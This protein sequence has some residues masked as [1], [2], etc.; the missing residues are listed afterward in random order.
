MKTTFRGYLLSIPL[1]LF[2]GAL[3]SCASQRDP[4]NRVQPNYLKKAQLDGEW[5]YQ[6]TVVD[7][8]AS[9][10]FTFVGNTDH[11]GISRVTW[12][13]QE[14]FLFARRTTEIIKGADDKAANPEKYKGE[15]IAT[16]RITSHFDIIKA[17]NP[18]TGEEL[19]IINENTTDRPWYERTYIRVDWA[20]NLVTNY[21]LD[22][23]S[24][25]IESVP[26]Y[27]QEFDKDTGERNVDAP[28]FEEDGSY[29][30]VTSRIFA[31]AGT[32]TFPGWGTYPLCWFRGEE[33]T[34]CGTGEYGIRHSFKRID[35]DHQYE[36]LPFKG[37]QTEVFGYFTTDR[38]VYNPQT[39]IREQGKERYLNRHN[40]WKRW[41]DDNGDLI[42]YAKRE[43]RPIVYFVNRGMPEDLK[44]VMRNVAAQYNATFVDI[45]RELGHEPAG[46]V[47]I[48]CPNNPVIEGDPAECGKVGNSPRLGDLRYSFM[49]YVP[50]YMTY[51]LLGLGPSNNDPETGEIISG[52]GY[53]YHHNNTAAYRTQEMIELLNGN[54]NPETYVSG[55]DLTEW[56]QQVN[57]GTQSQGKIHGLDKANHMVDS[58]ANGWRSKFWEGS[59]VEITPADEQ[60][61]RTMGFDK[62]VRPHFDKIYE[63]GFSN[64]EKHS[65]AGRLGQLKGT[66]IEDLMLDKEILLATGLDPNQRPSEDQ[67]DLASLVRGGFTDTAKTRAELRQM[68]A[69][70]HNMYL[71]EMADDALMGLAR[72]LKDTPSE[73]TYDIIRRTIYTAVMAHEVGHS[74]G[75][76]HNFGGSDDAINYHDKYWQIRDDGNVGP[77]TIDPITE[78]EV[79]AKIYNYAYSSV[80]DYAGRYTIDGE[81]IGKYDKAAL[82]FG[83]AQK[84]QVFNDTG[85]MTHEAMGAWYD[86]SGEILQF[87]NVGPQAVHY[88]TFYKQM[89]EK[90]YEASNRKWVDAD[91]FSADFA[92]STV[93]GETR[94]R[95][96]YIY[97]S[98]SRA[99]LGDSCLTRDFG[100][101]SMERMSNML[102]ELNTWYIQRSFPRG[103]IGF[104]N[105]SYI[106]AYYRRVY[107][108]LKGWNDLYGLY[109]DLLPTFYTAD[110][111][112]N[113]LVDPVNGWGDKTWAVQNAFNYLIQTI[114]TPD[115]GNYGGPVPQADGTSALEKNYGSTKI[116][117]TN[118]RYY[119]TS[120]SDGDR[121]CGYEWWE[122]LHHVGNY[123][124]KIMAVIALT[125]TRTN[126]VGRS[127]PEDIREWEVGYYNTFPEQIARINSA[128]MSQDFSQIGPYLENGVVK[129][130]N[131][132]GDMAQSNSG[133]VNP[134]ATFSIQLYWQVLGQ[135]RFFS[136]FDQS[137]L[138]D[139]TVFV[140]G[141]GAAPTIDESK[142]YTFKD[143]VTNITYAAYKFDDHVGGG[144]DVLRRANAMRSRS[145]LCDSTNASSSTDDDCISSSFS[146]DR[147]DSEMKSHVEMIKVMADL[148]PMMRYGNPFNP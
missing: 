146:K 87:L 92:T 133:L 58:I 50:K 110:Q 94:A 131:Y 127:T 100:A 104:S 119:Q 147:A 97:C 16:F 118:G 108:R 74:L 47:F 25:S 17:Y 5:Y 93:D 91:T 115:V 24:T 72:E 7:V 22:F 114:L 63:I 129:Y 111:V 49:A 68:Y 142:L 1:M 46:D 62:W 38:L 89:K 141:S 9:N 85:G 35:P 78:Q 36:P 76:M 41:R 140:L 67:K 57:S 56:I 29:F 6:R 98:H 128:M 84:I 51:G 8:P 55:V 80:M 21:N 121:E 39:G 26:Y 123:L 122:C 86:Q 14:N 53:V 10:G 112:K 19:N 143:P 3:V 27:V 77:R 101:D 126:F 105:W 33:F 30:D 2:I 34:E 32:V 90:L 130:P 73:E 81:G 132:T 107:D 135:A 20:Q 125:D 54:R 52:I 106:N 23:E 103:A 79:N 124:D 69:E 144:Q 109:N 31:R 59:R 44:P 61:Q 139:S 37:K 28:L 13:I 136:N 12:D 145:N 15:V 45:V 71:P 116:D 99:N 65:A 88:T 96:P 95:V 83:Y 11:A 113:F 64:G 70:R 137:F 66:Y 18:T 4:I 42:D 43:L 120:W 40:L 134:F 60:A 48:L 75:L 82:F 117:V 138:D 102:E 148:N